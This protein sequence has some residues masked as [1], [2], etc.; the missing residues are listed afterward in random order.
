MKSL[1]IDEL[2]FFIL[3]RA[4]FFGVFISID[5][6]SVRYMCDCLLADYNV[7]DYSNGGRCAGYVATTLNMKI[8]KLIDNGVGA[9]FSRCRR[10]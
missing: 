7:K 10:F 8:D 6:T 2:S 5:V 1:K 3:K 4:Q 9:R